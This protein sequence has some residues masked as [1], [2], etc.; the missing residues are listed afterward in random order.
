V[1]R[2]RTGRLL[3]ALAAMLLFVLLVVVV[4]GELAVRP[5]VE[6]EIAKGLVSEFALDEPPGVQVNGFPLVLKAAQER[7]DGIDIAVDGQTFEGLRVEAVDLHID[8]VR[9]KTS[10]LLGGGGTIVI[11]GGAGSAEIVDEDLTQY[12]VTVQN[13]PVDVAFEAGAVRVSG[14]V[15]VSGITADASVVG[16]LALDGDVLRFTPTTV[17]LGSLVGTVDV[18]QVEAIV[19]QQFA[20]TAPVPQLQGVE[21]RAV[22]IGDGQAII[23]AEFQTLTVAY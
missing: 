19:R 11:S 23:D 20:F 9:F 17:D 5:R 4:V 16:T 1:Q 7:L 13:L 2:P 6:D 22:T 8:E 3:L 12:L 14:S 15:S 21:L 18:A 10:E